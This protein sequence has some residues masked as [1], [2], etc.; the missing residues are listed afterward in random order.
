MYRRE[1][2]EAKS[3]RDYHVSK[4]VHLRLDASEHNPH[5]IKYN[6]E[7]HT[8]KQ[9]GGHVIYSTLYIIITPLLHI[10]IHVYGSY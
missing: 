6:Q 4:C 7:H 3:I 10:C 9:E 8:I 1:R 5:I 2:R